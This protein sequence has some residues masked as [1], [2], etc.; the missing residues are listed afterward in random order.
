MIGNGAGEFWAE[1][2][3]PTI[4][5]KADAQSAARQSTEPAGILKIN[6][7]FSVQRSGESE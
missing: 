7:E 1:E 3:R 4:A 6:V 2:L 5:Q